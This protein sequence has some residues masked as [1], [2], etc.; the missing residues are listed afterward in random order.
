MGTTLSRRAKFSAILASGVRWFAVALG[1]RRPATAQPDVATEPI[2]PALPTWAYPYYPGP[3]GT[4]TSFLADRGNEG[5]P[6][7]GWTVWTY[8]AATGKL[9]QKVDEFGNVTRF[10]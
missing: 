5:P 3:Q 1:A 7:P 6:G 9:V 10:D 4:Y 8:D 2:T